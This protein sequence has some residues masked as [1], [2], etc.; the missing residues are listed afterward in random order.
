MLE[1]FRFGKLLDLVSRIAQHAV[2]NAAAG[3][4]SVV[5]ALVKKTNH[6]FSQRNGLL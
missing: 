6:T 1:L 4:F 5:V 3:I 2:K